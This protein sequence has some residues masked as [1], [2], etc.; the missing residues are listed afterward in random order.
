MLSSILNRLAKGCLMCYLRHLVMSLD[1]F[2]PKRFLYEDFKSL[3]L[4]N[5]NKLTKWMDF[6]VSFR[7]NPDKFLL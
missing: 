7:M 3:M 5:G 2:L 6:L 4:V 1:F